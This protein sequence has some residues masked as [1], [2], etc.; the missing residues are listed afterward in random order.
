MSGT[1]IRVI[2]LPDLGTVT[3]AS[4]FVIDKAAATGRFSALAVKNYC[5]A[6]SIAEAPS[7]NQPYG[8]MNG[9]WTPVLPDAPSNSLTFGRL[10][11]GWASVLP[12]AP[13]NGM[14]YGRVNGSY[15]PVLPISGGT[16]QGHLGAT[17]SVT[18]GGNVYTNALLMSSANGYEWTFFVQAGTGHHA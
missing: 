2:D 7:T 5:A 12:E 13:V 16:I 10:N 18:A 15:M 6:T 17:G 4:S 9:A 14:T 1:N 11:G 8:R 3:D